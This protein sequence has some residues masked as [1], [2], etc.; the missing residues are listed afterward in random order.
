MTQFLKCKVVILSTEKASPL[1]LNL[2]GDLEF[3][4]VLSTYGGVT[5][6]YLYIISDEKIKEGNYC[7]HK[8]FKGIPCLVNKIFDNGDLLLNNST[9]INFIEFKKIIATTDPELKLINLCHLGKDWIDV[10]FPRPSDP[11]IKKYCELG[12]IDEVLVEYS[13]TCNKL[14]CSSTY[15]K[16]IQ[17]LNPINCEFQQ[18]KVAP[19]NTIT[20]RKLEEICKH[21]GKIL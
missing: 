1:V 10:P 7:L 18:L 11:F 2:D 16:S 19:D 8:D 14:N 3:D 12:G 15:S 5:Q 4:W 9:R 6:Q 17:C 20:I 13:N 21:C